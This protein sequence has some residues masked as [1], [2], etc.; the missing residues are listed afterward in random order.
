MATTW[1]LLRAAAAT[2]LLL[3]LVAGCAADEVTVPSI[4]PLHSL[5][6]DAVSP[7]CRGAGSAATS[8][9][10][11]EDA[12]GALDDVIRSCPTLEEWLAVT[13]RYPAALHGAGALEHL[14]AR[15]GA[16]PGLAA[17]PLC[18]DLTSGG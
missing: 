13:E 7:A 15:C 18:E 14:A 16:L 3:L 17:T 9:A 11:T 1:G 12:I 4:R 2:L 10:D 5:A 8:L 6:A